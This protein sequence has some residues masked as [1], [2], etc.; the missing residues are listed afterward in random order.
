MKRIIA[1]VWMCCV[2]AAPVQAEEDRGLSLMERGAELFME[3]MRREMA[4]AL[5]Q[6][7]KLGPALRGFVEEMGP[8]FAEVLGEIQDWSVYEPPEVLENGDIIIRRKPPAP[9]G[10]EPVQPA[11]PVDI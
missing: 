1:L 2:F 10:D 11:D 6:L 3:G 8:A 7:D 5:E 9:E 4:P